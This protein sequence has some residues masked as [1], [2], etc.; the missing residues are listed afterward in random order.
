MEKLSQQLD[1]EKP[2]L[3]TSCDPTQ[4]ACLKQ[5]L[6]LGVSNNSLW[7]ETVELGFLARATESGHKNVKTMIIKYVSG[8]VNP[9][10]WSPS[11]CL[12]L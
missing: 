7:V 12:G 6:T 9:F 3:S 8:N 1:K 10:L 5:A 11:S 2:F 4:R